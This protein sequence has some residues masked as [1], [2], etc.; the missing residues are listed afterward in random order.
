MPAEE[1]RGAE[2]QIATDIAAEFRAD[3]RQPFGDEVVGDGGLGDRG[4]GSGHE[5]KRGGQQFHGRGWWPV[6][7]RPAMADERRGVIGRGGPFLRDRA[8]LFRRVRLGGARGDTVALGRRW[9]LL[10][11]DLRCRGVPSTLWNRWIR[12]AGK[13]E[14]I[15]QSS[16]SPAFLF[17]RFQLRPGFSSE[18]IAPRRNHR[19]VQRPKRRSNPRQVFGLSHRP[20]RR[21][22]PMPPASRSYSITSPTLCAPRWSPR[23]ASK[24]YA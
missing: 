24:P 2:L 4:D 18:P 6:A 9:H 3:G 8:R 5:S 7:P 13:Q 11:T 10:F 23:T 14:R 12:K 21:N 17:S 16:G 1:P 22:G 15:R 20:A 19:A